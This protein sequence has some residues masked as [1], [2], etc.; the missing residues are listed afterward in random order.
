[1][2]TRIA[3]QS[4]SDES[5]LVFDFGYGAEVKEVSISRRDEYLDLKLIVNSDKNYYLLCQMPLSNYKI[6]EVFEGWAIK[7]Y[8]KDKCLGFH[9]DFGR[10]V[11]EFLD[12]EDNYPLIFEVNTFEVIE[13]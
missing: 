8:D 7:I 10:Y 1:V 3:Q 13:G 11:I 4:Y 12:D 2:I 9:H 6:I 5:N